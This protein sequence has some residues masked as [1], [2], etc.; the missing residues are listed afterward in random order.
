MRQVDRALIAKEY[1][2]GRRPPFGIGARRD[3]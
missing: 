2:H 1:K 3:V